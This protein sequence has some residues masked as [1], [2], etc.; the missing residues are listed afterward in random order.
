LPAA[1]PAICTSGFDEMVAMTLMR[2]CWMVGCTGKPRGE[3]GLC[4]DHIE[5][6]RYETNRTGG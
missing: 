3:T 5:E 4:G 6:L 2:A 1:C